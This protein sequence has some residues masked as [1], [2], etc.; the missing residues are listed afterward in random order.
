MF[1]LC[2][3][4]LLCCF[5]TGDDYMHGMSNW[6]LRLAAYIS[7]KRFLRVTGGPASPG[8]RT[9]DDLITFNELFSALD[10]V[11][12]SLPLGPSKVLVMDLIRKIDTNKDG[13]VQRSEFAEWMETRSGPLKRSFSQRKF[14]PV[15]LNSYKGCAGARFLRKQDFHLDVS[16]V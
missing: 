4:L 7:E 14:E 3:F 13:C 12:D 2:A 11:V 1:S 9:R 5:A 6:P 10:E 15:S 8:L 16:T